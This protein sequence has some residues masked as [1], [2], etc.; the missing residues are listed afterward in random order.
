MRSRLFVVGV[1]LLLVIGF[2]SSAMAGF[3]AIAY[4]ANNGAWAWAN[5][6]QSRQAAEQAALSACRRNGG[7]Y[8]QIATWFQGAC[9]SLVRGNNPQQW[10][11]GYGPDKQSA[12]NAAMRNCGQGCQHVASVCSDY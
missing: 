5:R 7:V 9:G 2:S 11:S 6:Y 4:S 8:C 1:V 12:Y 10:G 3:G